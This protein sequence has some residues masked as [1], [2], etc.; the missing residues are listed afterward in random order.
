MVNTNP[1]ARQ[2]SEAP[3]E[4]R[5]TTYKMPDRTSVREKRLLVAELHHGP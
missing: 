3:I 5:T 1:E 2:Q 4:Q